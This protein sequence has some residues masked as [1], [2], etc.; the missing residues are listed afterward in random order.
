MA[1][2]SLNK[3]ILGGKTL[4]KFNL[5]DLPNHEYKLFFTL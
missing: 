5:T 4:L 2:L 1:V 3:K